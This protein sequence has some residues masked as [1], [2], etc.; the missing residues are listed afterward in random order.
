MYGEKKMHL[1]KLDNLIKTM[2]ITLSNDGNLK[3][4]RGLRMKGD[5]RGLELLIFI[6]VLV[7]HEKTAS[8]HNSLPG[9]IGVVLKML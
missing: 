3:A 4:E 5:I 2:L 9:I 7:L 1:S 8:H 6:I